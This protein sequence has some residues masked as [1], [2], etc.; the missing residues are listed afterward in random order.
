MIIYSTPSLSTG[1]CLQI[2]SLVIHLVPLSVNY[3]PTIYQVSHR[4]YA[5]GDSLR[6]Q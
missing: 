2:P 3:S 5:S 4:G 1:L 6:M